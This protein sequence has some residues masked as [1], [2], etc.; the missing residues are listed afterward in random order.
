M[1]DSPPRSPEDT[2]ASMGAKLGAKLF[3]LSRPLPKGLSAARA[4]IVTI[5]KSI[6]GN[7]GGHIERLLK[8]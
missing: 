7:T 6:T 2:E 1:L 5:A 8:G 3:F 4:E